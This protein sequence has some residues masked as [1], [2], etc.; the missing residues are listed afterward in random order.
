MKLRLSAAVLAALAAGLLCCAMAGAAMIGIYRNGMESLAQRSQLVKLSGKTCTRA[1]VGGAMRITI[2]KATSSC[3]YRTPVLGRDL[4]IAATERL[5]SGTPTALQ[6]KAYLGLMLRAGGGAKYALLVFPRQKKAQLIKVTSEGTKYLA[7]AK[8]EK[9]V[10]G[11]N[12]ANKLRLRAVN[13]TSGPEKG[14]AH[15]FAYVNDKLVGEAQDEA[16]GDLTGRASAVVVGTIRNG[17]G[18]VASVDD[19]VVRVPSPF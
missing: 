11:V 1:G 5:L 15:L 4:E 13:V 19:V 12:E 2:G 6:R 18:I 7:I 3:S 8:N 16:A 17:N 10:V 14:Q 9:A